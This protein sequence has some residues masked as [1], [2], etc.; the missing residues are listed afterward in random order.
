MTNSPL[1]NHEKVLRMN[2]NTLRFHMLVIFFFLMIIQTLVTQIA[3][4]LYYMNVFYTL[5]L[6]IQGVLIIGT[7][8]SY[9]LI[10]NEETKTKLFKLV[11]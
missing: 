9:S 8:L 2:R 7:T 3:N 6:V 5:Y 11:S 4:P 1:K 10:D